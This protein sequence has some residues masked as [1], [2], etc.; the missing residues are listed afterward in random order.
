MVWVIVLIW[1]VCYVQIDGLMK[2]IIGI[3]VCCMVILMLKL[4]LGVLILMKVSGGFFSRFCFSFLWI[5][6]I[7]CSWLSILI[8]LL[9]DSLCIGQFDWKFCFVMW[10]LL[11]LLQVM[12]VGSCVCN[13]LSSSEVSKLLE[14]LLVIMLMWCIGVVF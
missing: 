4:K 2:C 14:V 6:R 3:F 5:E 13:F 7:L 12:L 11:M 8:Q 1:L 9:I 10:A